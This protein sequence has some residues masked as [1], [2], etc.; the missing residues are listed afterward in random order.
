MPKKRTVCP[1][2]TKRMTRLA[3]SARSLPL[4]QQMAV[5]QAIHEALR[6]R[7]ERAA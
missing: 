7:Q 2:Y 1:Y 4:L 5:A 6:S 3:K